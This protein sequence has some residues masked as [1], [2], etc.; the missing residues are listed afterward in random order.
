M[1]AISKL[2]F[3]KSCSCLSVNMT[4][5]SICKVNVCLWAS[6]SVSCRQNKS[7]HAVCSLRLLLPPGSHC[8]RLVVCTLWGLCLPNTHTHT[9]I[10]IYIYFWEA[11]RPGLK[12]SLFMLGPEKRVFWVLLY[13]FWFVF[14]YKCLSVS[15]GSHIFWQTSDTQWKPLVGRPTELGRLCKLMLGYL[16]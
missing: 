15:A 5:L 3:V 4:G 11:W 1:S 9:H 8:A 13:Y 14:S 10:Y 12:Q 7:I 2:W 16:S 6:S